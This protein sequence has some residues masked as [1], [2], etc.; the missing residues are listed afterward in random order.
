MSAFEQ[1][2][3]AIR[4]HIVNTLGWD[5]LRPTQMEAIAPIHAGEDV[6]LLAPTAGGKTE[7]AFLPLLSRA[8]TQ[9]WT[10]LSVLYLCPLKALLNN[11]EPRLSRYAGFVGRK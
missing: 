7:A 5:D 11:L 4:Y 8:A 10:G 9:S 6:L 3:P 2:H 1:L